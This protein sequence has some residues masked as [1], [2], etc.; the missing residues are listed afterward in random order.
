MFFVGCEQTTYKVSL[1]LS[2]KYHTTAFKHTGLSF[3]AAHQHYVFCGNSVLGQD[4]EM[5]QVS[6]CS[7]R[8]VLHFDAKHDTLIW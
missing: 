3:A 8:H 4:I 2:E 6:F 7:M 5:I 1:I